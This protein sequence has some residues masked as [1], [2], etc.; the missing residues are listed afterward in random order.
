MDDFMKFKSNCE[1]LVTEYEIIIPEKFDD[2]SAQKELFRQGI[3]DADSH[4]FEINRQVEEL[5]KEIDRLT[6][7]AY[8]V[9]L[10]VAAISGVLCGVID[11]VFVEDFSLLNASNPCLSALRIT[12]REK[13]PQK[14][15]QDFC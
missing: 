14:A 9:D 3:A 11:A 7:H 2:P 4:I 6:N 13:M 15:R 5:N 8:G 1:D 12:Q 10:I